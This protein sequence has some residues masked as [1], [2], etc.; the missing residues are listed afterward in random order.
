MLTLEISQAGRKAKK[1][2]AN[3]IGDLSTW[4][5]HI[6][7]CPQQ[8]KMDCNSSMFTLKFA[9]CECFDRSLVQ[10]YNYFY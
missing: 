2:V 10:F 8:G 7:D 4:K 9:E 3:K 5:K 6:V 1:V